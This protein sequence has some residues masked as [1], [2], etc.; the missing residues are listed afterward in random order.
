M[1]AIDDLIGA[2]KLS[3]VKKI[4]KQAVITET[5]FGDLIAACES[6]SSILGGTAFR[7]ETFCRTGSGPTRTRSDSTTSTMAR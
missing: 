4:C 2:E 7:I 6:A 1:K 3:D 5:A